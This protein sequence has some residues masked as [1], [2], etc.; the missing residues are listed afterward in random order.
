MAEAKPDTAQTGPHAPIRA[1]YYRYEPHPSAAGE[2]R[3]W[4]AVDKTIAMILGAIASAGMAAV[5]AGGTALVGKVDDTAQR[6]EKSRA[7]RIGEIANLVKDISVVETKVNQVIVQLRELELRL[8][9]TIASDL[10][11]RDRRIEEIDKEV[12]GLRDEIRDVQRDSRR[13]G[14]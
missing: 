7:E 14:R 8:E 5:I 9:R 12:S 3:S 6:V 2:Q 11:V 4:I 13:G 10:E 1:D